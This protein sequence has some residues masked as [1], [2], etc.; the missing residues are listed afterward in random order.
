MKILNSISLILIL[1][2]FNSCSK[3]TQP[4]PTP[5]PILPPVTDSSFTQNGTPF[6]NVTDPR[7]A[8]IYQVNMRVFSA[9]GNWTDQINSGPVSLTTQISLPAYI[10]MVLKQ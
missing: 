9:A 10:F 4:S 1:V 5:S 8:S 3:S 7:D 2:I 6:N